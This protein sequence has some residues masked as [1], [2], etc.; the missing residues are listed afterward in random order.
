[1]SNWIRIDDDTSI[2]ASL[3]TC[4]EYQ[5]FIDEMREQGKYHQPDHWVSD[6]FPPGHSREI[7]AGI[8]YADTLAFCSWLTKNQK[9]WKYRVPDIAE[10][11][12][13]ALLSGFDCGYWV[14]ISG[15][16]VIKHALL[17]CKPVS[18][19]NDYLDIDTALEEIQPIVEKLEQNYAA[20]CQNVEDIRRLRQN[21]LGGDSNL[22]DYNRLMQLDEEEKVAENNVGECRR[23]AEI[24]SS[25]DR[26]NPVVSRID[27]AN[28]VSIQELSKETET[29]NKIRKVFE[30]IQARIA[31]HSPAFEGIR[32]VRE[33]IR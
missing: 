28:L 17:W 8:R 19:K 5:L 26:A 20:A 27:L 30:I 32:L 9:D 29:M 11:Q 4:A 22:I 10:G 14:A 25:F 18:Q 6:R 1:M 13:Y 21:E 23:G 24:L 7:I 16:S 33:R 3:V 12:K 31:G 15:K 2:D